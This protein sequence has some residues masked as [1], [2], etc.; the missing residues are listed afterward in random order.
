MR[1]VWQRR[2]FLCIGTYRTPHRNIFVLPRIT[3]SWQFIN[4]ALIYEV[5]AG[6]VKCVGDGEEAEHVEWQPKLRETRSMVSR[7]HLFSISFNREK[8]HEADK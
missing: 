6:L 8:E 5:S 4:V 3:Y 7:N 2:I 1:Q